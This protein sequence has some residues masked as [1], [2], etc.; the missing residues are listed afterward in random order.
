MVV[1][2]GVVGPGELALLRTFGVQGVR[3]VMRGR[4]VEELLGVRGGAWG[5]GVDGVLVLA[6][7]GV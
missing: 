2:F 1:P 5:W 3:G 6:V 4:V 7:V